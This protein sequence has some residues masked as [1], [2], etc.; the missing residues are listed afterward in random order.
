[1]YPTIVI[2]LGYDN[3]FNQVQKTKLTFKENGKPIEFLKCARYLGLTR[4]MIVLDIGMI[5]K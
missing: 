1:M 5:Q 4:E 3:L 2:H